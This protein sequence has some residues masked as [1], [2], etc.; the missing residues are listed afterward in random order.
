MSY[1]PLKKRTRKEGTHPLRNEK[2]RKRV[3]T[4]GTLFALLQDDLDQSRV[5][6]FVRSGIRGR[7]LG[8]RHRGGRLR[9][10]DSDGHVW[11]RAEDRL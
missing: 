5:R 7:G 2:T 4:I 3:L 8:V 10:G 9:C 11:L 1:H 6:R